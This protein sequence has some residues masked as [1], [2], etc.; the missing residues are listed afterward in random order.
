MMSVIENGAR[1]EVPEKSREKA[2]FA[3][4]KSAPFSESAFDGARS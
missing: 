4:Q 3:Q 1:S 2:S